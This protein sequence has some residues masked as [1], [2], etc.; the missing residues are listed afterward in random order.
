[1]KEMLSH[2]DKI[3]ENIL[4]QIQDK[5]EQSKYFNYY[6]FPIFQNLD[7]NQR[8]SNK[9]FSYNY[10]KMLILSRPSIIN[11]SQ[12]IKTID[13]SHKFYL[14]EESSDYED[15]Y[16]EDTK[17]IFPSLMKVAKNIFDPNL[18]M[19]LTDITF[20]P[21]ESQPGLIIAGIEDWVTEKHIKY[22][23]KEVPTFKNRY[24]FDKGN[25]NYNKNNE[26][27]DLYV[28]S[29]KFFVEQ[30]KRYAYI[31]LNNFEQMEIIGNFFLNPIKKL[32]PSYNSKKEKLEVYFAY[33]LLKITK[34]HWYGVILRNLPPNC[35]DKS[36]YNFTEQKVKNGIKYCL[37]PILIDDIFCSLVVCKE[38]EYAE[39]L[40]HELNNSQI[41]N[42]FIKA[43]LHPQ[44]CKI[45]TEGLYSN[46]E[47]FSKEGYIFDIND[48]QS[49]KCLN[50]AKTFM[51]FFNPDYLKSFNNNKPKKI[52]KENKNNNDNNENNN[53]NKE[54][55]LK[56]EKDLTLASSILDLFKKTNSQS[57]KEKSS[58][59]NNK[60]QNIS[61]NNMVLEEQKCDTQ[62]KINIKSS[63]IPNQNSQTNL[64]I[65][66]ANSKPLNIN[67]TETFNE[68]KNNIENIIPL[69]KNKEGDKVDKE[70]NDFNKEINEN[71]QAKYSQD[72]IKYYT[73]NMG[74]QKYYD[75]I[76][77]QNIRKTSSY[78]QR[79]IN[80]KD[81]YN[82]NFYKTNN[83]SREYKSQR[84]EHNNIKSSP[85]RQYS[86]SYKK[87]NLSFQTT[88][89]SRDYNNNINKNF[90]NYRE[91]SKEMIKERSRERNES[92]EKKK[93][94]DNNY[95]RYNTYYNY[96][97]RKDNDKIKE[98]NRDKEW[99]R[100]INRERERE[101]ERDF[102]RDNGREREKERVKERE[103][104]RDREKFSHERPRRY[105]DYKSNERNNKYYGRRIESL[106]NNNSRQRDDREK[107]EKYFNNRNEKN[108]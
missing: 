16:N 93:Y 33:D 23:L 34:N 49:E 63:I 73:Y 82:K 21:K 1:M 57:L 107:K 76:E 51:E 70:S 75:Y 9:K 105:N 32:Y 102:D 12:Q 52:E 36:I 90:D 67:K 25:N 38:L 101:R 28:H 5:A 48:E 66:Q 62:N 61:N 46:Y 89:K 83:F 19:I 103:K 78:K 59:N 79:N 56:R 100:D 13:M 84:Y 60:D 15:G 26:N 30:N 31:K 81:D 50:H 86:T 106:H 55:N 68:S 47:T 58:I 44:I 54:K 4:K 92:E 39:K 72:E 71:N 20:F 3:K 98:Y 2:L 95:N 27:S 42:K 94:K 80:Y 45:R 35:N 74:D 11:I 96:D 97:K 87:Q 53:K 17:H 8:N 85:H 43:H 10:Q 7:D 64:D 22:F 40:C 14:I 41:N 77:I 29:I 99:N 6:I 69:N 65:N 91:R 24:K 108:L 104:E 37:N 88:N 18:I